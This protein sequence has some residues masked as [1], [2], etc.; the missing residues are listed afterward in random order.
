VLLTG[1]NRRTA[2]AVAGKL[3]IEE[4]RSE[5]LPGDKSKEIARLQSQGLKVAMVGDGINDAPA[6]AQADLGL[7]VASGTDVAIETG[8]VVLVRNDPR[9]VAVA[10]ELGACAFRKIR[11]NLFWAFFYNIIAIPVAAGLLYPVNGFLLNPAVAG[12]A[13]SLSS[14]SV[15]GNSLLLKRFRPGQD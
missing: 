7:A 5:V 9:D 13:M 14:L 8:S 15:V 10:L 4:T 1:D 2:A 3:D 6:L 12:A 11:Q